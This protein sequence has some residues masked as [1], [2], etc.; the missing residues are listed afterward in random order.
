MS[1]KARRGLV[2][3]YETVAEYLFSKRAISDATLAKVAQDPQRTSITLAQMYASP[4]VAT[5]RL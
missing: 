4:S 1:G 2:K 3:G 5:K